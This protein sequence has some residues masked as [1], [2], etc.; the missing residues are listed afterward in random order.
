MVIV[1]LIPDFFGFFAFPEQSTG[2][3]KKMIAASSKT[4]ATLRD[5]S[6]RDITIPLYYPVTVRSSI[7]DH[8]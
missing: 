5:S 4:G 3:P 6:F 2:E 1:P 8:Q 7:P